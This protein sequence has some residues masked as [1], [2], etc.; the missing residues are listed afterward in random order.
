MQLFGQ[1]G[2][3]QRNSSQPETRRSKRPATARRTNKL[4]WKHATRYCAA[5]RRSGSWL[6]VPAKT[7]LTGDVRKRRP[8]P[9]VC[10]SDRVDTKFKTNL[11]VRK[12]ERGSLGRGWRLATGRGPRS[13]GDGEAL[14]PHSTGVLVCTDSEVL[15]RAV[16]GA[17]TV[18]S[19]HPVLQH[20]LKGRD[21]GRLL[22]EDRGQSAQIPD[23][24]ASTRGFLPGGGRGGEEP[25]VTASICPQLTK[26]AGAFGQDAVSSGEQV[27]GR[28]G[29]TCR[30]GTAPQSV[31]S[32]C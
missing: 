26:A 14:V 30:L 31:R 22:G 2:S 25:P 19:V 5:V 15:S 13:P 8:A 10:L 1:E 17:D 32:H 16:P 9:A 24:R 20:Q 6:H 11:G 3:Q 12:R 18:A 28:R 27:C 23:A 21:N 7:T 29:G 4:Q